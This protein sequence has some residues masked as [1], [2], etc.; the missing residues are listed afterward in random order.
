MPSCGWSGKADVSAPVG[1]CDVNN[2]L[3]TVGSG[4]QN[5]CDG[6]DAYMCADQSPWAVSDTL[7]YG[8]AATHI[9]GE[10]ESDW[11]CSCYE[12]TFT[13]T[14]LA[15]SGKK[16]IVQATNT[17]GDLN[18]NQFDLAIP[19]GGVG[20]FNGCTNEWGAPS[21]GWGAQYGGKKTDRIHM[22]DTR[23]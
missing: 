9:A 13:S 18:S 3:L 11:C 4:T 1:V 21:S 17:G 6:G 16:M 7:A 15:T 23:I 19:G 14:S 22:F 12:L 8:F 5:G 2:N 10:S 20:I